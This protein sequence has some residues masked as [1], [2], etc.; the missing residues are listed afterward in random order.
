MTRLYTHPLDVGHFQILLHTSY[1]SVGH[2][3][4]IEVVDHE[5]D[6]QSGKH[7]E[8]TVGGQ[9]HSRIVFSVLTFVA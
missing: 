4:S 8:V 7:S 1:S 9:Y 6:R 5:T 3:G 2:I